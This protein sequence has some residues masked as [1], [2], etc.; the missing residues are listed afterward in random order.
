MKKII[1]SFVSIF[2]ISIAFSQEKPKELTEAE[3][4]ELRKNH[5]STF[6]FSN[7]KP[8]NSQSLEVTGTSEEKA[9]KTTKVIYYH[10]TQDSTYKEFEYIKKP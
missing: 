10:G 3:K 2:T 6:T 9:E 5:T 8:N 4:E 1:L 7:S